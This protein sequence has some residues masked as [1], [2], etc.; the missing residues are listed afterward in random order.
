MIGPP[1]EIETWLERRLFFGRGAV[2]MVKGV[3]LNFGLRVYQSATPLKL[4]VPDF[5]VTLIT[6]PPVLPNSA[7]KAEVWTVNSCTVSGVK[8]TTARAMPT[9]VLLTPSASIAVLPERPPF[10][11][12][13]NPGTGWSEPTVASS[14]PASPETFGAVNA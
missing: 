10:T 14:L 7:E 3:A 4:L 9:P 8:L 13:L 5:V 1:A 2:P 12:R 6:P 11:F